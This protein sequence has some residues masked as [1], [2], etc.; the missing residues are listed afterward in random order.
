MHTKVEQSPDG[1]NASMLDERQEQGQQKGASQRGTVT[2]VAPN[3]A[4]HEEKFQPQQTV[5]KLLR[6]G[7]KHF[8]STG[9]LDPSA[10]YI[11]VRGT[12]ELES[13]LRLEEAGVQPGDLLKIRAQAT[14]GDGA[15]IRS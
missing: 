11:L 13:G 9:D 7:I 14:P 12:T 2:L 8:G 5:E 1:S 15:C 4:R 3:N 10:S 6:E